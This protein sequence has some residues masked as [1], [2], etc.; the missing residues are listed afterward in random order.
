[1]LKY[2]N[3]KKFLKNNLY[4]LET[5]LENFLETQEITFKCKNNTFFKKER[6]I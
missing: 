3:C 4:D 6:D 2:N 1:M 5:S